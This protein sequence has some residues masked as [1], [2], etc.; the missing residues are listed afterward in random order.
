M[1]AL[2]TKGVSL[3]LFIKTATAS[4][5]T[6]MGEGEIAAVS[7]FSFFGALATVTAA[8]YFYKTAIKSIQERRA[9]PHIPNMRMVTVRPVNYQGAAMASIVIFHQVPPLVTIQPPKDTIKTLA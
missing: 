9:Q 5:T 6:N 7:V 1:Q 4:N 3:A 8:L 2:A